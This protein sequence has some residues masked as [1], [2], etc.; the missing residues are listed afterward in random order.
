M[1]FAHTSQY[2]SYEVLDSIQLRTA[3]NWSDREMDGVFDQPRYHLKATFLSTCCCTT[4]SHGAAGRLSGPG[5]GRGPSNRLHNKLLN[6]GEGLAQ[7]QERSISSRKSPIMVT[8]LQTGK[9]VKL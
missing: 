2:V 7:H 9:V 3:L 1:S 6:E 8:A 4:G 5:W